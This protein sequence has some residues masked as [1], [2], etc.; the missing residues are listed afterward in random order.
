MTWSHQRF[1][2]RLIPW[3]EAA[4]DPI[5]FPQFPETHLHRLIPT[6]PFSFLPAP[7]LLLPVPA[8]RDHPCP[9]RPP[10][11]LLPI[12][13][14]QTTPCP[15]ADPT[16]VLPSRVSPHHSTHIPHSTQH[17]PTQ[18][19]RLPS[20]PKSYSCSQQAQNLNPKTGTGP[21]H[22][23][24]DLTPPDSGDL[25]PGLHGLCTSTPEMGV[26]PGLSVAFGAL[27][28]GHPLHGALPDD[29]LFLPLRIH[30]PISHTLQLCSFLFLI[31]CPPE[32]C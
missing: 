3:P 28:I 23:L 20:M 13:S 31:A 32:Q 25:T 19:G 4:F 27:V 16:P 22:F 1:A 24:S 12:P 17:S 7:G 2:Q 10:T 30:Y 5:S 11:S 26:P 18:L 6:T 15:F 9:A 21:T 8:R 14:P 29:H